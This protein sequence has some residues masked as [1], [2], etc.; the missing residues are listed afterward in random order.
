MKL[1][2][3]VHLSNYPVVHP[4]LTERLVQ[5]RQVQSTRHTTVEAD[6]VP[7]FME[8]L[9]Y[10]GNQHQNIRKNYNSSVL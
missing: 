2:S 10:W 8:L 4:L 9:L 5:S 1:T 6:V 3:S 7:G